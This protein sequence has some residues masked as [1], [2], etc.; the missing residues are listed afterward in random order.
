[1]V[2]DITGDVV[3]KEIKESKNLKSAQFNSEFINSIQM[4]FRDGGGARWVGKKMNLI[5]LRSINRK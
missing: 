4:R 5:F 3:P 2:G 1:L